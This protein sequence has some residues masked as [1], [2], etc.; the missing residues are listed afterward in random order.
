MIFR[1]T[2]L[3]WCVPALATA[4]VFASGCGDDNNQQK[5][6]GTPK[7][8][9]SVDAKLDLLPSISISPLNS[10][11]GTVTQ[12]TTS[13]T[14]MFTVTNAGPGS[15]DQVQVTLSGNADYHIA[16][17]TCATLDA[18]ATCAIGIAYSPSTTGPSNAALRADVTG[19]SAMATLS[20]TGGKVGNLAVSPPSFTF[21]NAIVGT[22]GTDTDTITVTNTGG[23][24][25]GTLAVQ[26]VGSDPTD[27]TKSSDT[28]N[29]QTLA[30]GASCAITVKFSPATAGNKS[31]GFTILGTP[32]GS[33]TASVSGTAATAAKL[34]LSPIT[35]NFGSVV[36]GSTSSTVAVNV[37][38]IGGSTSGALSATI[39]GANQTSFAIVTNT[40]SGTL[41]SSAT[42]QLTLR[43][44]PS[45]LATEAATL[46]V[47]GTPGGTVTSALSG[48]GVAPGGL[49]ID[50]TTFGFAATQ[51]GATTA[52]STFTVTNTGGTAISTLILNLSGGDAAQFHTSA[53][54]CTNA[55]LQP[56]G[57]CTFQVAFAP[58]T[59]GAKSATAIVSGGGSSVSTALTGAGTPPAQLAIAPTSRDFG[60]N[61]VGTTSS[62]LTFTVTN[63][64]G[65]A[66]TVPAIS[67]GGPNASQFSQTNNCAAALAPLTGTCTVSVIF[68]PTAI[69]SATATITAAAATGGTVSAN[70]FGLGANP[71]ALSVLP[72]N[73]SFSTT[74]GDPVSQSF[75]VQNNGAT[76]TGAIAIAFTGAGTGA[77]EYTQT[78]NC[79]TVAAGGTC[80]VTVTYNPTTLSSNATA[81]VSATPGGSATVALSGT[82]L[83][84]LEFISYDAINPGFTNPF[85]FGEQPI[86]AYVCKYYLVRNNT[87]SSQH[88][89]ET[90]TYDTDGSYPAGSWYYDDDYNHYGC[91]NTTLSS[92]AACQDVVC[93][94]PA[95]IGL[96]KSSANYSIGSG[97]ANQLD[98]SVK[99]T[100][101]ETITIAPESTADFGNVTTGNTSPKLFFRVTNVTDVYVVNTPVANAINAPFSVAQ[102]TCTQYLYPHNSCDLEVTFKPTTLGPFVSTL[103]VVST[104]NGS[105][106]G[107]TAQVDVH[108]TGVDASALQL[109]PS[110]FDFGTVLSG[111]APHDTTIVIQN[112]AGSQNSTGLQYTL[113]GASEFSL[114]ND[115]SAGDCVN[116]TTIANGTTCNVRIRFAP[117]NEVGTVGLSA[118]LNIKADPGAPGAGTSATITG[119]AKSRITITPTSYG[120]GQVLAGNQAS[121]TFTVTNVTNGTVAFDSIA[122]TG[123][124]TDL[125]VSGC[126][127]PLAFMASC[128]LTVTFAPV[129]TTTDA[130]TLVVALKDGQGEATV[131]LTGT[132]SDIVF[133]Q[134]ANP[135]DNGWNTNTLQGEEAA[136][137][138]IVPSGGWTLTAVEPEFFM[139]TAN[140]VFNVTIYTDA[141]G[142]PG[143]VVASWTNLP[144]VQNGTFSSGFSGYLTQS[145]LI[146]VPHTQLAAGHYWLSVVDATYL[147]YWHV[148]N[149][150]NNYGMKTRGTSFCSTSWTTVTSCDQAFFADGIFTLHGLVPSGPQAH[151]AFIAPA[152]PTAAVYP[153]FMRSKATGTLGGARH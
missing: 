43:Y 54:T 14:T 40:C 131:G 95:S 66:T 63:V 24:T 110:S 59:V 94:T 75:T 4:G 44:T 86:A 23:Q 99:G 45:A 126:A 51:V 120:F 6:A 125:S 27:F 109:I 132:S 106:R 5:D 115:G 46:T 112:P 137:D 18:G 47:T 147:G 143:S 15:S 32:G 146:A 62:P 33:A 74:I 29:G 73:L 130:A 10:D 82:A 83:P 138:F 122:F 149:V 42:C 127:A 111:D 136:D 55:T 78:S 58:S 64:G 65:A 53:D 151:A 17:N 87:H 38:N 11:F 97:A 49:S 84:R 69:G 134:T 114:L 121:K 50:P 8:G 118:Q 61:G 41:A 80:T 26:A 100:G 70:V 96:K 92:G 3:K 139:V 85:D 119:T 141:A 37:A 123:T 21:A 72:G 103:T 39:S 133:A 104:D 7:D 68:K 88:V 30:S 22:P 48:T 116:G 52:A 101:I 89:T 77:S 71:A 12:G 91:K 57:K 152:H 76:A 36:Q 150:A 113:T 16:S 117:A 135:Y 140:N 129:A 60:S 153:S 145:T 93:F 148:T 13:T 98:V 79:T 124:S 1:S 142:S 67:I 34:A 20:G 56:A 108:G 28:C 102:G 90:V 81:T 107:G 105:F 9:G 35:E 31:A 144:Y 19:S 2:L 25:T 128:T